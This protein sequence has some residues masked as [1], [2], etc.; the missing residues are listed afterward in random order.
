MLHSTTETN[1]LVPQ[2]SHGV[3]SVTGPSSLVV[4]LSQKLMAPLNSR[5]Q[6]TSTTALE[7]QVQ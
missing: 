6:P 4:C 3:L 1:L 5:S 2:G 7:G